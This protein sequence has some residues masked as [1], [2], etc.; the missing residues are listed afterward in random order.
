M[1]YQT[2]R[3][4][5]NSSYKQKTYHR[6]NFAVHNY[7]YVNRS[8]TPKCSNMITQTFSYSQKQNTP[9]TTSNSVFFNDQPQSTQDRTEN[10]PYFTI[11]KQHPNH[12]YT[13]K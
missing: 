8:K 1:D 13:N 2:I 4:V 7:N 11:W 6:N 5:T 10:Y 12:Y 3:P 9:Q